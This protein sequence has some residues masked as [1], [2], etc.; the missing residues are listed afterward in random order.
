MPLMSA[1]GQKLPSRQRGDGSA[2]DLLVEPHR[3]CGSSVK[4]RW[5]NWRGASEASRGRV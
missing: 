5:G 2:A 1:M 3:C 4:S